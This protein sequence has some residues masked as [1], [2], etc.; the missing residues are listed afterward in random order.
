[1]ELPLA[2]VDDTAGAVG[3]VCELLLAVEC[4]LNDGLARV[5]CEYEVVGAVE[6]FGAVDGELEAAVECALLTADCEIEVAGAVEDFGVVDWELETAEAVED[7]GAVDCE[8]ETAVECELLAA[9]C[10]TEVTGAVEDFGT[11]DCEMTELPLLVDKEEGAVEWLLLLLDAI[12]CVD[13][14][15]E[16]G[17]FEVDTVE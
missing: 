8:P 5:D 1:M 12:E 6:D 10:E 13:W 17:V 3:V 9:D 15:V 7:F 2:E 4:R 11:V 14:A 16:L